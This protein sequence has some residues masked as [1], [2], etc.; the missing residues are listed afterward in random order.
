MSLSPSRGAALAAVAALLVACGGDEGSAPAPD[1]AQDGSAGEVADGGGGAGGSTDAG[2]ADGGGEDG[3]EPDAADPGEPPD[4]GVADPDAGEVEDG[5]DAVDSGP[6]VPD[7]ECCA[8]DD[9]CELGDACVE[10]VCKS[11]GDLAVG[12]CWVDKHCPGGL[13]V[14]ASV[15]PCG[16]A[17]ASVDVPGSCQPGTGA[18]C[19]VIDT[20]SYGA[21]GDSLGWVFNG[22]ACVNAT[23]CGCAA[24]CPWFYGE[25]ADCATV[26]GLEPPE[27]TCQALDPNAYG[28]C[29]LP[30][31]VA[32]DGAQCVPVSGC[33]CGADCAAF[34]T[35]T[36]ACESACG[37][38]EPTC[39]ALDPLAYG[40]CGTP[41]G[42][43]FDGAQCVP[44]SGCDC[45][46][47]CGAFYS[48]L[49]ECQ[50]ACEVGP[51]LACEEVDPSIFGG[52]A[53][54]VGVVWWQGQCTWASGCGCGNLC[55]AVFEDMSACQAACGG[56][57]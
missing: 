13:C 15:C 27:P 21:C 8:N 2:E 55:E 38:P 17:C 31:G 14:G 32:F 26:C 24:D 43:A 48:E 37:A 41:L 4:E 49:A 1:I 42:I 44:V 10:G 18:E 52:C 28:D 45:G 25:A 50:A 35:D 33:D 47:D 3:A 20:D 29:D 51:P 16:A 54:I 11:F 40:E 46:A 34:Y 56:G 36:A 39:Q 5:A 12:Q 9:Q 30:L 22:V 23:G 19:K 53:A 7:P 6:D 57:M